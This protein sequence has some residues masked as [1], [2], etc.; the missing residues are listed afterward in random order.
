MSRCLAEENVVL[1]WELEAV[2]PRII[3][4]KSASACFDAVAVSPIL[5]RWFVLYKHENLL[6]N[7]F[8]CQ[9]NI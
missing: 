6:L 1:F 5:P 9:V 2:F 8:S 7:Y 3:A 4:F